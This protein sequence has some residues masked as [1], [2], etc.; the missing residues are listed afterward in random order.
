MKEVLILDVGEYSYDASYG[1]EL[2]LGELRGLRLAGYLH[3]YYPLRSDERRE[4]VRA[5]EGS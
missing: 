1:A 5:D 4:D 2:G 3:A